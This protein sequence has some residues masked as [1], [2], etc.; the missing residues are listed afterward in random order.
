M[1]DTETMQN[2]RFFVD[3]FKDIGLFKGL[4]TF[5]NM[6]NLKLLEEIL[7]TFELKIS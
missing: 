1:S 6:Y 5:L 4:A 7:V 3:A 2:K